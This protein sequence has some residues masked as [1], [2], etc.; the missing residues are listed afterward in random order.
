VVHAPKLLRLSQE[1]PTHIYVELLSGVVEIV[2]PADHVL[3]DATSLRLM[4]GEELA[5]TYS[6]ADVLYCSR[7]DIGIPYL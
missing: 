3:I 7:E 4:D 2:S 6:R 1:I 5:A